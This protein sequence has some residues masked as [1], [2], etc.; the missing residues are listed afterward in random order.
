MVSSYQKIQSFFPKYRD[1]TPLI[2]Q[3]YHGILITIRKNMELTPKKAG[4]SR[5]CL[6]QTLRRRFPKGKNLNGT[7]LDASDPYLKE[8]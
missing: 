1:F 2:P 3:G 4:L 5:R 7:V 8:P 6:L